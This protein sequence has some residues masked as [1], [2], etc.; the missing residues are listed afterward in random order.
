MTNFDIYY[1][2]LLDEWFN[3]QENKCDICSEILE[4]GY[5]PICDKNE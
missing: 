2:G 4:D 1:D 3:E 5:C